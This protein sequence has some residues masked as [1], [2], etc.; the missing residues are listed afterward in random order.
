MVCYKAI[1]QN[2]V[3][4]H[5]QESSM[6]LGSLLR[7]DTGS[8]WQM[9]LPAVKLTTLLSAKLASACNRKCTQRNWYNFVDM[10]Y[11]FCVIL[12]CFTHILV[13]TAK[14]MK[15]EYGRFAFY[16]QVSITLLYTCLFYALF[17]ILR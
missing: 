2:T 1:S 5:I 14:T 13:P 6:K 16:T 4:I 9:L 7:Q 12:K 8:T 11:L 17:A 15:G 3:H 10:H